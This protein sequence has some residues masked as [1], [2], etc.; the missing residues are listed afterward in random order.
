VKT[1]EIKAILELY[2]KGIDDQDPAVRA[3]LSSAEQDLSL[4]DLLHENEQLDQRVRKALH[5]SCPVPVNLKQSILRACHAQKKEQSSIFPMWGRIAALFLLAALIAILYINP[6]AATTD[7]Q[8]ANIASMD[9]LEL[10]ANRYLSSEEKSQFNEVHS[11]DGIHQYFISR[12]LPE[13]HVLIKPIEAAERFGCGAVDYNGHKVSLIKFREKQSQTNCH[14]F[15]V[16]IKEFPQLPQNTPVQVKEC[17]KGS[18]VRWSCSQ[19]FYIMIFE[20]PKRQLE[21]VMGR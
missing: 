10:F 16:S 18:S 13:P 1:P 19:R 20:A 7:I 17:P 8:I 11:I 21:V 12:K 2:R 15:V 9:D 14:L 5:Q 6:D 3:A 4:Q